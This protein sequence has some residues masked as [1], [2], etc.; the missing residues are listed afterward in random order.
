MARRVPCRL[1]RAAQ[2]AS[3]ETRP[4]RKVP[5]VASGQP[6]HKRKPPKQHTTIHGADVPATSHRNYTQV[7]CMLGGDRRG[8]K[9]KLTTMTDDPDDQTDH[10]TLGLSYAAERQSC[11]RIS[12]VKLQAAQRLIEPS[13][14]RSVLICNTLKHIEDELRAEGE[15]GLLHS[16]YAFATSGNT[17]ACAPPTPIRQ[18][19][20][21]PLTLNESA[22]EDI[23]SYIEDM[24]NDSVQK[25]EGRRKTTDKLDGATVSQSTGSATETAKENSPSCMTLTNTQLRIQSNSLGANTVQ[26]DSI[27]LDEIFSDLDNSLYDLDFLTPYTANIK[28]TPLSED[29]VSN[30]F[31]SAS[32]TTHQVTTNQTCRQNEEWNELDHIMEVLVGM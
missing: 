2:P 23:A 32:F 8:T 10:K 16:A 17:P 15:L 26:S 25:E 29:D 21:M 6:E 20:P 18:P 22:A 1:A 19:E 14:R 13:L 12:L 3:R 11:F 31:S 30:S 9:R 27:N 5:P 7:V 28:L 24:N 4:S